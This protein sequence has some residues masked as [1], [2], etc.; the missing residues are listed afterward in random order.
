MQLIPLCTLK[1]EKN[2]K[3]E[4]ETAMKS[5]VL[6]GMPGAGK[7][8]V[9]VI[10]AKSLGYEFIDSDLLIQR[11]EKRL[12]R[13][14]IAEDGLDRFIE[15]ENEVNCGINDK[16]AVIATG[17][18]A[19]Y[20]KEAMEFFHDT[21][22]VVYLKLDYEELR[23]RVGDP[24]KRGVVLRPGQS[25]HDLF[26]ERCPLYEKYAHITIDAKGLEIGEFMQKIKEAVEKEL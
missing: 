13:E 12:L 15:I 21:A 20:G 4:R 3:S 14:I 22:I 16:N 6:T 11:R 19:I 24:V 26:R 9:G 8:T 10:L 5:I 2:N 1:I 7:S 23:K 18:S 17:G 25:F